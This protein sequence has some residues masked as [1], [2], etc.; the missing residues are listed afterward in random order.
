MRHSLL[1][2]P[3]LLLAATADAAAPN[4]NVGT[5]FDYLAPESS[6]LLKRVRNTGDATAYVRVEIAEVHYDADGK[7]SETTVD[8]AALSSNAEG[9]RGVIASPS[10]MIVPANGQQATRLV[11]RGRREKEQYYRVRFIPVFPEASQ[12]AVSEQQLQD[13]KSTLSTAIHVFTGYGV[14]L[15]VAP[16]EAR[17]QT[18]VERTADGHRL[19][20]RGNATVVLDNIRECTTVSRVETCSKSMMIHLRPGQQHAFVPGSGHFIRLDLRE[21]GD[22]RRIDLRD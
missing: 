18:D 3:L 6:N 9:A 11:F 16:A 10:R 4:I 21:G 15:F 8:A 7:A 12:F 2:L 1:L 22:S 17:Y 20:N 14:L 19:T 5:M 13:Y